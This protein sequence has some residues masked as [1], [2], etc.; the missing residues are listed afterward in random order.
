M[1]H[2]KKIKKAQGMVEFALLAPLLLLILVG[3]MEFG[4][5]IIVYTSITNAVR[6]G[7]RYGVVVQNAP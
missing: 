1:M 2:L 5:I 3:T 7:A 4:R 6:E